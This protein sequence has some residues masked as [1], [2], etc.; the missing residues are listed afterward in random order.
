MK[1]ALTAESAQGRQW[2]TGDLA[3]K[4]N[5]GWNHGSHRR[6]WHK[7]VPATWDSGAVTVTVLHPVNCNLWGA[8]PHEE[9][10]DRLQSECKDIGNPVTTYRARAKESWHGDQMM[11]VG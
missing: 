6:E 11:D 10:I 1:R 4:K 8:Q 7:S 3:E 2:Y 9:N 5:Q